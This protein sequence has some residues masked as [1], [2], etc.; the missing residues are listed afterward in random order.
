MTPE[1]IQNLITSVGFP[2]VMCGALAWYVKHLTD[3]FNEALDKL[4]DQHDQEAKAMTK[5]LDA[6]TLAL[7]TL[8]ERLKEH[9]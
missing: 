7:N 4:R 6:N 8:S 5:S 9:A 2:I 3:K 1:Q